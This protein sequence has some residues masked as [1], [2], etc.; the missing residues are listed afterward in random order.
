MS[1]RFAP[2]A[3]IDLHGRRP[4]AALELLRRAVE[5]GKYR[6]KTLEAIHG[7]GSGVLR[8]TVRD[9]ARRSNLVK[10]VWAG[11]DFFLPGGGG[12]TVLFL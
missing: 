7:Q 1:E 6:G 11:E 8:E 3:S 12:V 5:S 9:W 4:D 2:D 10:Q